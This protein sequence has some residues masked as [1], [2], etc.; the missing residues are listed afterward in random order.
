M[1]SPPVCPC[2]TEHPLT[3]PACRPPEALLPALGVAGAGLPHRSRAAPGLVSG[4]PVGEAVAGAHHV[5][6]AVLEDEQPVLEGV[7]GHQHLDRQPEGD[8][9]ALLPG[10]PQRQLKDRVVHRASI[11]WSDS[12]LLSSWFSSRYSS[13]SAASAA[14]TRRRSATPSTSPP[15]PPSGRPGGPPSV[16]HST[17]MLQPLRISSWC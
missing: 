2:H 14:M 13:V 15:P 8:L 3:M 1:A 4:V 10:V 7:V 17:S 6:D 16:V 9:V 11:H 5:L 12:L